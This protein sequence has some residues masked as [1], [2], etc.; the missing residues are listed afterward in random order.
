MIIILILLII[1]IIVI[2]NSSHSNKN[3]LFATNGDSFITKNEALMSD[4]YDEPYIINNII[5]KKK[6]N[7]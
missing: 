1:I 7:I 2:V 3:N 6:Q 5:T 4:P